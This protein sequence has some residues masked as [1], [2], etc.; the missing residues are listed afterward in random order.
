MRVLLRRWREPIGEQ[1]LARCPLP[2]RGEHLKTQPGSA[3]CLLII[4][5]ANREGLAFAVGAK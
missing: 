3:H 4:L 2:I 5:C 1:Q